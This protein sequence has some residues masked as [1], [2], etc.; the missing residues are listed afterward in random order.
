MLVAEKFK[1]SRR[2]FCPVCGHIEWLEVGEELPQNYRCPLCGVGRNTMLLVEDP[3]LSKHSLEFEELA[4]GFWRTKK[5]PIF[6]DEYNH[7]SYVLAHK[8]GV[9][10]YDAPSI[11]TQEAIDKIYSLGK[12]RLLIASHGDFIGLANDWAEI[13]SVPFWVGDKETPFDGN[14]IYA[15]N[16]INENHKLGS[17]LDLFC[18]DGHSPSSLVLYWNQAENNKIL[19]VGDVLTAWKHG[20]DQTQLAIFQNPPVKKDVLDLLF[21]P[22]SLLATCTGYLRNPSD[23][24]KILSET[25]ENCARPWMGEKG[26]IWF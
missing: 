25:K 22:S 16:L 2:Y 11:I 24:L 10:L 3:R 13:L 19:C 23:K 1:N 15:T 18:I 26:G 8:E 5:K 4:P 6:P 14:K 9:I 20:K 7:F 17:D 12:P 21:L